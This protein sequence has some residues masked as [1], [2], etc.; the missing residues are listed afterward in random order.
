LK[1]DILPFGAEL[2]YEPAN[3]DYIEKQHVFGDKLRP[4]IMFGYHLHQGG[5]WSGDL[6]VTDWEQILTA[7]HPSFICLT[8]IRRKYFVGCKMVTDRFR[9]PVAEGALAPN[10]YNNLSMGIDTTLKEFRPYG[11][12]S[13]APRPQAEVEEIL[14]VGDH[15]RVDEQARSSSAEIG[16]YEEVVPIVQPSESEEDYWMIPNNDLLIRHHVVPRR[17]LHVP[18]SDSCPLP[19]EWLDV[20]RETFTNL[21]HGDL[22]WIEDCWT[23]DARGGTHRELDE[24]FWGRTVYTLLK[25]KL[26]P[27]YEYQNGR[28]TKVH[29]GSTRPEHMFWNNWARMGVKAERSS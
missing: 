22:Q 16:E 6:Y 12:R 27:C 15:L 23:A 28:L 14:E 18:A 11:R 17:H 7:Q 25:K 1:A 20:K 3:P 21:D 9:F 10:Y 29:E 8:R 4:G 13:R 2:E 19:L 24:E 5:K 26:I